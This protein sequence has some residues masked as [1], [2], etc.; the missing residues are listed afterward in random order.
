MFSRWKRLVQTAASS[1]AESRL[2]A[3]LAMLGLAVG[4]AAV[5]VMTAV[6]QGT[7]RKVLQSIAKMG[8]DLIQVRAGKIRMRGGRVRPIGQVTT[9]TPA[10]A[11]AIKRNVFS[12]AAIS[13]VAG[14]SVQ[15]KYMDTSAD[16]TITGG[17][18]QI[19]EVLRHYP[20][21]GRPFTAIENRTMR[22]VA[23]IGKTVAKNLFGE[24]PPLGKT[25]I[26]KKLPF[27]VIGLLDVKGVDAD[28]NDQDDQ[29]LIPLRTAM[30]R[31][32]NQ[33]HVTL[34]LIRAATEQAIPGVEASVRRILRRRHRLDTGVPKPN[35][36]TV[37]RQT[38]LAQ[39][40]RE[41][42]GVFAK[43]IVGVAAIS[44]LVG[45]VGIMAVML[46]AVGERRQ[47]IGVRR[48]VGAQRKDI[49]V[50]FL[51]EAS[52][53]GLCGGG[54]GLILGL[55]AHHIIR[56][57][58]GLPMVMPWGLGLFAVLFST[59]VALAFGLYPARRAARLNPVQ[60]LISL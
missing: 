56:L 11:E 54:G 13:P 24:E 52:L 53:M 42:A 27:Q 29:I 19:F 60:A 20:A 28:G 51:L 35:D 4:V 45:G 50:Q 17:N 18:V 32:Y 58:T 49:A 34:I 30:K 15:V 7:Q 31:I 25:I 41:T 8:T 23:L 1:V 59:G 12:V 48:A 43:V 38:D 44:L 47:E 6:G 39:R 26:I 36:F 22:R 21:E 3:F 14:G 16:T 37:L 57:A 33:T 55:I 46:I 40:H 2:R 9:L 5:V 10:D